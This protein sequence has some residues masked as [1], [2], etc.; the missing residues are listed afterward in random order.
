MK[1]KKQIGIIG[2][3][4]PEGTVDLYLKIINYYQQNYA[5]KYD[6]DFPSIIIYSLPIP[7][8]VESLKNEN[9]TK[10]LLIQ[11]VKV[12]ENSGCDFIIIA[13]STVQFL[14][15]EVRQAVSIPIL[16]IA[17]ICFDFIKQKKYQAIGILATQ[18]T[19]RKKIYQNKF[20][21]SDIKLITPS[22]KDQKIITKIIM[23]QLAGKI[24]SKEKN[25]LET[26]INNFKNKGCEVVLIACTDLPPITKKIKTNI[27]LID[28]SEI[29]AQEVAK[30]SYNTN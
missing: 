10:E 17:E 25:E 20:Q 16:G 28:C 12:L 6:A 24:K 14:L 29:Y 3:M 13:C 2:G 5:A 9:K 21:N 26:I 8:V 11:A 23:K 22:Q 30:I 1:N 18:T 27:P 19:I 15:N 4:G 7:D